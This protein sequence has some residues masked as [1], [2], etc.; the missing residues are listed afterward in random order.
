MVS[1][2]LRA[3]TTTK[4]VLDLV[5]DSSGADEGGDNCVKWWRERRGGEK[6]GVSVFSNKR[7]RAQVFEHRP[8]T[9]R[10]EPNIITLLCYKLDQIRSTSFI[11]IYTTSIS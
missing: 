10:F 2:G 4:R 9:S 8:L 3:A 1:R 7:L 11:K 5:V 6:R